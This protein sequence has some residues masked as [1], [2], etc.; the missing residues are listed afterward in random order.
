MSHIF[1]VNMF[2]QFDRWMNVTE[3]M[4]PQTK[5]Y[6]Y[7]SEVC[8]IFMTLATSVFL[9]EM[10]GC[11]L[12]TYQLRQVLWNDARQKKPGSANKRL[13]FD[14][15]Y[16]EENCA[17]SSLGTN[18]VSFQKQTGTVCGGDDTFTYLMRY[19]HTMVKLVDF[20]LGEKY[21]VTY[22]SQGLN[23]QRDAIQ[24]QESGFQEELPEINSLTVIAQISLKWELKDPLKRKQLIHACK[25]E[26]ARKWITF[27]KKFNIEHRALEF[28]FSKKL[29]RVLVGHDP[30][31]ISQGE[32]GNKSIPTTAMKV[33]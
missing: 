24:T 6:V 7:V 1:S 4:P 10:Y 26:F 17:G 32:T 29:H 33:T 23:N 5:P 21:M 18:L 30:A 13:R 20:L 31:Y 14:M 12:K 11:T 16:W 3:W 8:V 15:Q 28:Y 25:A 22:H 19:Q 27:C 2:N 9:I